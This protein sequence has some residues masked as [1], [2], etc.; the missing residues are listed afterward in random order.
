MSTWNL[1]TTLQLILFRTNIHVAIGMKKLK[2]RFGNIQQSCLLLQHVSILCSPT[3]IRK[4]S[5]KIQK[6]LNNGGYHIPQF[7]ISSALLTYGL[8]VDF[9]FM[10]R[11]DG[12]VHRLGQSGINQKWWDDFWDPYERYV[13]KRNDDRIDIEHI[14]GEANDNNAEMPTFIAIYIY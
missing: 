13:L 5:V 2:N 3:D 1:G 12:I 9:P 7:I 10:E 8:N 11:V 6:T 4:I 14:S